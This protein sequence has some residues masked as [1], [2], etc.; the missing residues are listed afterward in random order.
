MGVVLHPQGGYRGSEADVSL[1][2]LVLIALDEGKEL[3]SQEIPVGPKEEG[4]ICRAPYPLHSG[5]CPT[6]MALS[7]HPC[8]LTPRPLFSDHLSLA[9]FL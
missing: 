8:L 2:A 5:I 9:S 1:T 7:V 6:L 3:C 4:R